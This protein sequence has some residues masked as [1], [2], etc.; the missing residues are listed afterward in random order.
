MKVLETGRLT[1]R[2][3]RE[4]D[5]DD[6]HEYA[7]RADNVTYM[8][9]G[10]NDREQTKA[11]IDRS[12][13]GAA[14]D[15]ALNMQYAAVSKGSGKVIGSC[16]LRLYRGDEAEVGWIVNAD[17]WRDGY[18][19]EM[20]A[21]M[22]G[23]GFGELRLR[24]IFARCDSENVGSYRLMEKIGMRREGLFIEARPPHKLSDRSYGDELNYAILRDEWEAKNEAASYGALPVSF[25]GHIEVPELCDGTVRLVCTGKGQEDRERKLV[26]D[27]KFAICVRGEKVGNVALR[28][29]YTESL[30][31]A[32]QIGYDVDE[33]HRGIGYAGRACRLLPSVAKAHGMGRLLIT[34]D[35]GNHASRRV[36]EKLGAR[37]LRL[38]RIPEWHALYGFGRRFSNIYEWDI[39]DAVTSHV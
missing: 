25:G 8:D 39:C 1:L 26:P 14:E 16:S 27:Y 10:P 32:G 9:F 11:F 33:A 13:R 34:N 20:G 23:H 24:R 28:I 7:G 37:H 36:C 3:F 2:G 15:P 18:G 31:Y 35:H 38:A 17:Y 30:Y 19:S 21:A 5:L 12:I 22:L 4:G 6:V 29:G